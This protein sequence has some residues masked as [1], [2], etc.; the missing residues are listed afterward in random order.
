VPSPGANPGHAPFAPRGIVLWR[1]RLIVADVQG[2]GQKVA[3]DPLPTGDVEEYDTSTGAFIDLL[4]RPD[5][6]PFHPRGVVVGP[7]GAL[8]VSNSPT[9]ATSGIGGQV[10]RYADP[11]A[12]PQTVI[13]CTSDQA[14]VCKLNRPEGLVFGPDGTLYV[15][16]FNNP[17]DATHTNDKI[18]EYR[19]LALAG[20]IDL[21]P[22][23]GIR[24]S[25]QALV[26]GPGGGLFV[27]ILQ[28]GE[29]RRYDV[30]HPDT[31]RTVAPPSGRGPFFLT[32]GQTD[33]GTLAYHG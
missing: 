7:D 14:A 20:Q 2:T 10:L 28:T 3:H 21:D 29:I 4:P 30:S 18:L 9:L 8:Y 6:V 27:P 25:A 17:A 1:D 33:P 26:F 22:V 31:P 11:G 12:A 19:N 23:G 24:T 16:S 5:G 13:D 15:T 32:F